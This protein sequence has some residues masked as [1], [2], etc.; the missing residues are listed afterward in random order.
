M[1]ATKKIVF[2]TLFFGAALLATE[3]NQETRRWWSH[4]QALANDGMEGRDTGSEGYRKAASYVVRQFEQNGLKPAGE[5]GYAQ[6][7]PLH[8]IRLRSDRSTAAL[9]R[10]ERSKKLQ[11]LRQISV[12]PNTAVPRSID[13]EFVFAGSKDYTTAVD[14][15]GKI[16]VQMNPA[17]I[18]GGQT[19]V[20][21]SAPSGAIGLLGIDSPDGLE[22][23]RWPVQYA[24]AMSIR[25]QNAAT[26]SGLTLRFNPADAEMLFEGTGHTYKDLLNLYRQGRP[27]PSFPLA[28][29][30]RA[31]LAIE[32]EDIQSDNLI[33]IRP[34]SDPPLAGEY[35]IVSA[36]LDG[37]GLGEP[38]DGDHI[39]NGAFDD[40]AYVA[41]LIETAE[42]LQQSNTKLRRSVVFAV[43]T[44][45]EKGL[46]GSRYF[47]QHLT[48]PRNQV[49]ANVNLDQV[50]P[51]FPLRRLTMIARD[52]STLGD[53]VRRLAEP[54]GIQVLSDQEPWRNLMRRADNWNF[55]QI[56]V[57][58]TGFVLTPEKG[59]ADEAIYKEWYARRYHTPLDDLKQPWDPSAAAKFN[60]FFLRLVEAIANADERPQWKSG[61]PYAK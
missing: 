2:A 4:V 26:P 1:I 45:E 33:A 53:V 18:E 59:T 5:Q 34:G 23:P 10:G 15:R 28:V 21:S 56:G 47:T 51:L 14:V 50:R 20:L 30:L 38:W 58:A 3:P 55:M 54:M 22:P 43:F 8:V 27:L 12:Q 31:T 44:G 57:P 52:D 13:A 49:V 16:V 25:D 41:T 40:A 46:L 39:Y 6:T 42:R 19:A 61:S 32:N 36:H 9:I 37:Y 29:R 7:V 24:V 17:R 60:D 48:V 11:W 35:V